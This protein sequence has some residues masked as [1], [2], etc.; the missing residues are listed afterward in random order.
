MAANSSNTY[1]GSIERY[2]L[3]GNNTWSLVPSMTRRT[4]GPRAA[5]AAFFGLLYVF[6]ELNNQGAAL[7]SV[8]SCDTHAWTVRSAVA[9]YFHGLAVA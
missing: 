1:L 9:R 8:E 3:V 7:N 4:P 6:C 5:A 2:Y